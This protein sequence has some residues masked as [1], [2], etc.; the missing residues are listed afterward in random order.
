[1]GGEDKNGPKQCQKCRLDP[2]YVLF[3]F[4]RVFSVLATIAI[5]FRF[6]LCSEGTRRLGWVGRH[7]KNRPKHI[8][9]L[10][11]PFFHIFYLVTITN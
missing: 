8:I 4:L 9:A 5:I 6:Y 10:G 2:R 7:N 1:M 11:M 3:F